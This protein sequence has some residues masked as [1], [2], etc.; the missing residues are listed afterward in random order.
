LPNKKDIINFLNERLETD[1][2]IGIE[3]MLDNIITKE[4][5]KY[6]KIVKFSYKEYKDNITFYELLERTIFGVKK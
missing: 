2:N 1:L 4:N 3:D 6:W 5:I